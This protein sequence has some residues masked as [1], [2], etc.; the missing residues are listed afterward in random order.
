ML[1][2]NQIL[3]FYK[4]FVDKDKFSCSDDD[5]STFTPSSRFPPSHLPPPHLL[6][7]HRLSSPSPNDHNKDDY[8]NNGDDNVGGADNDKGVDKNYKSYDLEEES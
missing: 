8:I 7:P 5:V 3:S 2:L 4:K 6:P 1:E